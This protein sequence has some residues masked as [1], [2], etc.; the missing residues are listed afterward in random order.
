MIELFHDVFTDPLFNGLIGLHRVLP[1]HDLGAAIVLLTIVIRSILIWPS[2]AQIKASR[3]MQIL[4]PKL[5][6]LQKKFANDRQELGR[7]TMALYRESR[8]NPLA[9]CLPI[10]IQIPFLIALYQVFISG[11]EVDPATGLLQADRLQDLYPILREQYATTPVGTVAFGFLNLAANHNI[12]VALLVGA[13]QFYQAKMLVPAVTPPNADG[14]KDE[15]LA[16][17]MSKQSMY[18]FPVVTAWLTYTFPVGLGIYLLTTNL[19]SIVQQ[20]VVLRQRPPEAAP[21]PPTPA[22]RP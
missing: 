6:E 21:A 11:I 8:V 20:A 2:L 5:K 7:Q 10:L 14:A 19:F 18:I 4:Q 17:T 12:L 3:S 16:A 13:S 22:V 1:G 9:S 15:S